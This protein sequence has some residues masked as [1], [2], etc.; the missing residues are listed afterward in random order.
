MWIW[1]HKDWSAS[2]VAGGAVRLTHTACFN[3][4]DVEFPYVLFRAST[5]THITELVPLKSEDAE[6]NF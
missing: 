6:E 1:A 3:R 4:D 2:G 5:L